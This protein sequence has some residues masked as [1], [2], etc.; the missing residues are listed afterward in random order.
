MT[1]V[2]LDD[3]GFREEEFT[4]DNEIFIPENSIVFDNFAFQ[5]ARSK[6]SMA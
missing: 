4:L 2:C 3:W 5:E 6:F 1:P